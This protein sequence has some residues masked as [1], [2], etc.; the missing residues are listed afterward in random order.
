MNGNKRGRPPKDNPITS[1]I[2]LAIR[3]SEKQKI[4][5]AARKAGKSVSKYC[6]DILV[7][8]G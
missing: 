8:E 5:R 1:R 4:I 7:R 6:R 3:Q 2:I